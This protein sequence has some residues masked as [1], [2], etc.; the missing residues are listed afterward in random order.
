MSLH[1]Q[2]RVGLATGLAGLLLVAAGCASM[3]HKARSAQP[4]PPPVSSAGSAHDQDP[5]AT[6]DAV[7]QSARSQAAPE[8][9]GAVPT[10][11]TREAV[12]PGAPMRYT[13]KRGDTLWGISSMYLRDPWLWPEIWY[14]NPQ[15]HNPHLIYPGDVLVL[16]Y[17][18][19]GRPRI[20]IEHGGAARAQAEGAQARLEPRLRSSPVSGAIPAIP[21]SAIAAFLSR[22][23]VLTTHEIDSAPHVVAFRNNH[24]IAGS[25]EDAYIR[26][27]HAPVGTRFV[28][29]HIGEKLRDP[30]SGRVLGYQ[31]LYTATAQVVSAAQPEKVQLMNSE[32]ETIR[33][34]CLFRE[35]GGAPLD[36]VPRAPSSPVDGLIISVI[37]DVNAIGQYDI[38]VINRG[39]SRGVTPGTVLAVDQAGQVVTD[40]GAAAYTDWNRGGAFSHRVRLPD[41]RAGTLLVFKSYDDMSY[42]LVVGASEQMQVGDIVRNP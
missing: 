35:T 28:V 39:T 23:A 14:D 13:V 7:D 20:Y 21:Y 6:Q 29:L 42:A 17:A 15:I 24:Q 37:D 18:A 22:P 10:P 11:L 25:G 31:G 33:G 32:R 27:L 12:N 8:A 38:V 19:S 36:F 16:A 34:D 1:H 3:R 30:Q 2:L 41:E 40:R 5:T 4:A 26:G 9:P